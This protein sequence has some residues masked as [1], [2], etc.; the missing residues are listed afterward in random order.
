MTS[1]RLASVSYLDALR[2][3]PDWQTEFAFLASYSADLV[4]LVAALLAIAG[5]D[6]DRGS[7]SKVDFV[8]AVEQ[9]ADRVRLILQAGRLVAPIKT[10]RILS[11]LDRYVREDSQDET[12][13]SW[14][15]KATLCKHT[16][17]DDIGVQWRLWVGSRNLTRDLSWD[18]G[19]TLIGSPDP[20]GI[21]IPGIADLGAELAKRAQLP[22]IT[23]DAVKSELNAVR[24][25]VPDGCSVNSLRLLINDSVRALPSAPDCLKKLIVVSPFLDGDIVGRLGLWGDSTTKR[26]I[27][28]SRSE[29]AKLQHQTAAPLNGFEQLLCMD[30]PVP[31]DQFSANDA[32]KENSKSDDEAPEP[33]GLHAK[34]LY[35]VTAT[36][37]HLWTGS[38]NAT[39]RGWHG[40]NAEIIAELR[41]S[42]EIAAGLNQFVGQARTVQAEDLGTAPEE[43][44]VEEQ[45]EKARKEVCKAWNVRQTLLPTGP[46]LSATVD[47]H[48]A[49]SHITLSV[50]AISCEVI[51]W[52]RGE[53]SVRL[54][55]VQKGDVTELMR[56]RLSL[57]EQ[58]VSWLMR[59]PCDPAP[60]AERDRQAIARYLDPKTF[61]A[62]IRSELNED[63][64]GDGG[65]EWDQSDKDL[66]RR[67]SRSMGPTWWIPTL[68][69]VLK[70]W[71]RDPA[72]LKSV[73]QKLKH[74]LSIIQTETTHPLSENDRHA[75]VQFHET[76][77]VLCGALIGGAQ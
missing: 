63:A 41:I 56:V 57:N 53:S 68:E 2:P 17:N 38:A 10:P 24:W 28:S 19:L 42:D 6:D 11:I 60:D 70:A 46:M 54:P 61:L 67:N 39:Q 20:S 47:L 3:D 43:D 30:A 15:P 16:L 75:I 35:A 52:P 33:R 73:D 45:L 66:G 64:S 27:V 59:A 12:V 7:G 8:R 40:P 4:A 69:E 31:D 34:F 25:Q 22:G 77:S 36:E 48:P 74:Y 71:S 58:S 13:S 21:E 9:T 65:G 49:N 32:E 29:L 1:Q 44:P 37:H 50:G 23:A 14:H 18:S 62:W 51:E 76:W 5:L 72:S 55:P 26:W